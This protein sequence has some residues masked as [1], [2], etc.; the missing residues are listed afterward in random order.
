MAQARPIRALLWSFMN[1]CLERKGLSFLWAVV[2]LLL[3]SAM[4]SPSI[5]PFGI[6]DEQG[7]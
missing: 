4:A 5:W 2:N 6:E 7:I 3:T 1:E